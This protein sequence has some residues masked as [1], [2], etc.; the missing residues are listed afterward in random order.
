[1]IIG[2]TGNYLKPEFFKIL[3]KLIPL[4]T[5]SGNEILISSRVQTSE[6]QPFLKDQRFYHM[7]ELINKC[8]IMLSIGGDGTIFSTV[9]QMGKNAIPILGIHIGGLGFLAEC[10]ENNYIKALNKILSGNYKTVDR[11]LLKTDVSGS[12]NNTYY[13]INDVVIDHGNSPRILETNVSITGQH[14]NTYKSDGIIITTPVGSTA[15]SL[16]AGG[17]IITQWLDV[18][19]L[20]PICPHSLSA[21]PIVLPSDDII[22]IR[23]SE[24]QASMAITIDGQIHFQVD[25]N[26][27]ISI[28]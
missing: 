16:S 7:D 2:C 14:L 1:M 24:E 27:K 13:A 17:P 6:D 23:F 28:S 18:I 3:S 15:Y 22:E 12:N 26:T 19:T 9:R 8:D 5:K 25:F 11:M 20:T 21:R 4:I 10:N